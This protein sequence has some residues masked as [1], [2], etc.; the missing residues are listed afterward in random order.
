MN[1]TSP[2]FY[3]FGANN[4]YVRSAV[5]FYGGYAE[6]R[7][8]F[9]CPRCGRRE[10]EPVGT[11]L[12]RPPRTGG[13]FWSDATETSGGVS[14]LY[15]SARVKEA[16]DAAGARYGKA[17]SA[18]VEPPYPKKL[19]NCKPPEYFHITG[20]LGARLD[21]EAS[22]YRVTYTCPACG[23][24]KTDPLSKPTRDQFLEASWNRSDIFFTDLSP[25]AMFCTQRILELA[26]AHRWTNF[27]FVPLNEAYN[28]S[29]KGIDYTKE[30]KR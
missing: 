3:S 11:I 30:E 4:S 14:G 26:R 22:G 21:F 24:I 19:Q 5:Q 9:E 13:T 12:L 7:L 25:A 2:D 20:E 18:V 8:A 29:H 16:L 6:K 10:T 23:R 27:R 15:V 1:T 28:A 17:F